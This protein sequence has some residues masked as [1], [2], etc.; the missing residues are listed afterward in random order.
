[1]GFPRL[2]GQRQLPSNVRVKNKASRDRMVDKEKRA[3]AT[4]Q[5]REVTDHLFAP[6]QHTE[7]ET[8]NEDERQPQQQQ[9]DALLEDG[10]RANP[11]PSKNWL[12]PSNGF[13]WN[14][15]FYIFILDG[16]GGMILSGG[17]NFAI[18]YVMYT[19]PDLTGKPI[20]LFELPNTLAGDAAVTIIVQCL[21]TWFIESALVATDLAKQGVQPLYLCEAPTSPLL[22]WLFLL[23]Q[24]QPPKFFPN[25]LQQALRG[26]MMAFPSFIL[27]WPLSVGVLTELGVPSGGDYVYE[28][29][30]VP[31]FFKLLLGGLLGLVS[32]PV[33]VMFWLVKA[34]WESNFVH[35]RPWV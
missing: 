17:I 28:K 14:Q 31:Q 24:P 6:N 32:T 29:K 21:I 19:V 11:S 26:F 7:T 10:A 12:P 8:E 3:A 9:P 34:G 20:R 4:R 35:G 27:F 15:I 23:D 2:P 16:L 13:T 1:M 25:L 18:A 33:M 5:S 30:W 22:R